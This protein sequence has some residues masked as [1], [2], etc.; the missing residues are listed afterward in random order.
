MEQEKSILVS[1]GKW[2]GYNYDNKSAINIVKPQ[3]EIR[4]QENS[5]YSKPDGYKN[6]NSSSVRFLPK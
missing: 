1:I 3:D 6:V 5:Q 4:F 2:L